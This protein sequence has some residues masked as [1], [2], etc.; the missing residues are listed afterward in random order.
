M[1]CGAGYTGFATD[2]TRLAN[3]LEL[4]QQPDGIAVEQGSPRIAP[5][6]RLE[7]IGDDFD[8]RVNRHEWSFTISAPDTPQ[9]VGA[10]ATP[11]TATGPGQAG[12]GG[13]ICTIDGTQ[14]PDR[15]RG[16]PGNDVICGYGGADTIDGRGGHDLVY[17][18]PGDDRITGG[19]GLDVLYGNRGRDRLSA[20]DGRRDRLDGGAGRDT[21]TVDRTRDRLRSIEQRR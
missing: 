18:G 6:R 21:A 14:G 1:Y 13:S 9:D 15:L 5:L 19:S 12:G 2:D 8:R 17:G 11:G 16:T 20:R 4:V 7:T 10:D 3:S